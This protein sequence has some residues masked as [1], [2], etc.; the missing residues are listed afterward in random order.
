MIDATRWS[1]ADRTPSTMIIF[2]DEPRELYGFDGAGLRRRLASRSLAGSFPTGGQIFQT[3]T[4]LAAGLQ[5]VNDTLLPAGRHDVEMPTYVVVLTDDPPFAGPADIANVSA[6]ATA[7]KSGPH[8]VSVMTVGIGRQF[9]Q[10]VL[11]GVAS[12][13]EWELYLD[14]SAD[15]A[16]GS[17]SSFVRAQAAIL[18]N[19]NDALFAVPFDGD[20]TALLAREHHAILPSNSGGSGF[21]VHAKLTQTAESRGYLLAK[22]DAT[23]HRYWSIY[24][25]Q[26][27]I[28]MYYS[29]EGDLRGVDRQRKR[30]LS[31]DPTTPN[32][33]AMNISDGRE[34]SLD[35]MIHPESR[36]VT[37]CV[38]TPS[39]SPPDV[40][41]QESPPCVNPE[42][43]CFTHEIEGVLEDCGEATPDC[44]VLVGG[45]ADASDSGETSTRYRFSGQISELL[46]C[47]S[48][49]QIDDY[50]PCTTTPAPTF[51][52]RSMSVQLLIDQSGS[53]TDSAYDAGVVATR[54]SFKA[55]FEDAGVLASGSDPTMAARPFDIDSYGWID[56]IT[57]DDWRSGGLPLD[58]PTFGFANPPPRGINMGTATGA[59]MQ[60]TFN[61]VLGNG[62]DANHAI[63]VLILVTDGR[64]REGVNETD[65]FAIAERR[66]QQFKD[67]GW[68]LYI[69]YVQGNEDYT[70]TE[71]IE[72][73]QHL[74]RV[75]HPQDSGYYD[76]GTDTW[77]SSSSERLA[78]EFAAANQ[79]VS[80]TMVLTGDEFGVGQNV[81]P[82]LNPKILGDFIYRLLALG[83]YR[84]VQSETVGALPCMRWDSQSITDPGRYPSAGLDA[85][86]CRNPDGRSTIWCGLICF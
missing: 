30:V 58:A 50:A 17:L 44:I 62:M 63:K 55:L 84:G 26:N 27:E 52:P 86:F 74:T 49:D 68:S 32:G 2:G 65:S 57:S 45:R 75:S 83:E 42:V 8:A 73:L 56:P 60:S 3:N 64:S 5:Y 67:Q 38:I 71:E 13:P 70:R 78:Q 46:V 6:Q 11:Q 22:S 81:N 39:P 35:L 72:L 7:L 54:L 16:T 15:S 21:T 28:S 79:E 4:A 61:S 33:T 34:H 53:I 20:T 10:D 18:Q 48:P 36:T 51:D 19:Q 9:N 24:L 43:E 31:L 77:V 85:N 47:D 1:A 82:G 59:A 29:V 25:R 37:L 23:G 14:Y 69:V 66:A 76:P 80:R 12:R 40:L 41:G